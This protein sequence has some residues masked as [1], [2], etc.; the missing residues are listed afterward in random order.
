[1]LIFSARLQSD[2]TLQGPHLPCIAA[3]LSQ[4]SRS[5]PSLFQLPP[6]HRFSAGSIPRQWRISTKRTAACSA[7]RP[8][9]CQITARMVPKTLGKTRRAA[10][11]AASRFYVPI[12]KMAFAVGELI[13]RT[14][15][16]SFTGPE[17][18]ICAMSTTAVGKSRFRIRRFP[19]LEPPRAASPAQRR[20]RNRRI[21]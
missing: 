15:P 17:S 14:L 6:L 9:R 2:H 11:R 20:Q 7:T 3:L 16:A 21:I 1:M 10:A 8:A 12:S 4:P 18:L 19:Q 5:R 13:S